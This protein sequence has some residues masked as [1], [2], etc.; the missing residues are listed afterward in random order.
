MTRRPT[1]DFPDERLAQL[2]DEMDWREAE[3]ILA[4]LQKKLSYAAKHQDADE[5]FRTQ[6]K[7][8]RNPDIKC[9]AVRHVCGTKASP[10][11]DGVIWRTSAE[12]MRAALSLTSKNY[13]ASPLREIII[14]AR[15]TGKKRRQGIPT[16]P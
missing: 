12:K 9:L 2:W 11:V 7:I 5:V 8:V 3:E 4:I 10:G 13:H 16:W 1:S 15:N 6:K 14:E